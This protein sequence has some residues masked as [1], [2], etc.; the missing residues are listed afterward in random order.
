MAIGAQGHD[1][2]KVSAATVKTYTNNI[3]SQT[4]LPVY[5]TEMDL[6]IADDTQ[7]ATTM[8]D[9]V[10]EFWTNEN[11]KGVTYWGYIVG[12]TWRSNTGLMSSSGTKRAALTWLMSYLGR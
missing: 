9:L 3:I 2:A 12:A 11:I 4:G 5:I 6:G 8:K 7:Q 1:V 10:T